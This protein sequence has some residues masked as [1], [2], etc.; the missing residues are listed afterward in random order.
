MWLDFARLCPT[1]APRTG[2]EMAENPRLCP[3]RRPN[4]QRDRLSAGGNWIR[5][6]S[7][8]LPSVVSRVS[9]AAYVAVTRETAAPANRVTI[10]SREREYRNSPLM[11]LEL[12]R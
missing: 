1:P 3:G 2:T 12:C 4:P 6:F 7:S 9:A 5:N 8:A 10:E 11:R